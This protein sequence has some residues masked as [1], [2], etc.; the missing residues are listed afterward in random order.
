MY[1]VYIFGCIQIFFICELLKSLESPDVRYENCVRIVRYTFDT[2]DDSKRACSA[3]HYHEN[4]DQFLLNLFCMIGVIS[5]LIQDTQ[6]FT[7]NISYWVVCVSSVII[8]IYL[9]TF[10]LFQFSIDSHSIG[11]FTPERVILITLTSCVIFALLARQ[12]ALRRVTYRLLL[13]PTVLYIL[14]LVLRTSFGGVCT[15]H[16]HHAIVA[17]F[18]SLFVTQTP[19]LHAICIGIVI[20]AINYHGGHTLMLFESNGLEAPSTSFMLLVNACW[21]GSMF[22]ITFTALG[23]KYFNIL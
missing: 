21:L 9:Q 15:I 2:L 18:L 10:P 14:S 23:M 11:S 12:I 1:K 5:F 4:F 13:I 16:L 7:A 22:L 6:R 3:L 20:Q 19:L 8:Y 17:G